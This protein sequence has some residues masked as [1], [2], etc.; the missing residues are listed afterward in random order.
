MQRIQ[1]KMDAI[2]AKY[3][4]YKATD[5][6]KRDQQ[7]EMFDLQKSEGVNMFGG[8]L[9]M[10]ISY[11]LLYAFYEVLENV[12][13]LRHA[14]WLWLK[15]PVGTGPAVSTAHLRDR[16]HVPDAVHDA[17]ARH[18]SEAAEDHGVHHAGG[19]RL[20]HAALRRGPVAYWAGSNFISIG[21]QYVINRT[22]MGRELRELA[23]KRAA[24]KKQGQRGA[25]P[26]VRKWNQKS[27]PDYSGRFSFVRLRFE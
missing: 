14:H 26:Q 5:P 4:K 12:I 18:G 11:P 9:P 19:L 23:I 10:L 3:A 7:K 21:Q 8:C 22:K 1:P 27:A 20:Y 13:E 25:G 2:K 16:V 15:R 6:R 24:R 17:F